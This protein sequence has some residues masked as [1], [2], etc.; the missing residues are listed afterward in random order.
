MKTKFCFRMKSNARGV[1][2]IKTT[3]PHGYPYVRPYLLS[4]SKDRLPED[5]SFSVIKGKRW[6]DIIVYYESEGRNF[7]S[8][9]FIDLLNR[10]VDMSKFSY[11]IKIENTDLTYYAI[12]NLP[13]Y[14]FL[15]KNACLLKSGTTPCFNLQENMPDIFSLEGTNLRVCSHDV[16]DAI[17]KAKLTNVYISEVFGLTNEESNAL[18]FY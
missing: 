10:F 3:H 11:P 7:Y 6:T 14:T 9:R 13:E 12:Y 5:V 2:K 8:Q 16:K 1:V 4:T 15:N 17:E 18:G